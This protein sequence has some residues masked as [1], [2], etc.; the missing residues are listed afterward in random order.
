MSPWIVMK[1]TTIITTIVIILIIVIIIFVFPDQTCSI[2]WSSMII[3]FFIVTTVIK[4]IIIIIIVIKLIITISMII[5]IF[6][7]R[8]AASPDFGLI[9]SWT[10]WSSNWWEQLKVLAQIIIKRQG[11]QVYHLTGGF[12]S[13]Y[14]LQAL[15]ASLKFLR[16]KTKKQVFLVQN[17]ISVWFW[18]SHHI[19]KGGWVFTA[20]GTSQFLPRESNRVRLGVSNVAM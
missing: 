20:V 7:I 10:V 12:T 18:W 1:M 16:D 8:P 19:G 5:T 14:C 3:M 15:Y 6:L 11:V 17:T 9:T 2:S 4:L 13:L